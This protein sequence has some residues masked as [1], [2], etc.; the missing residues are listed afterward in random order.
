MTICKE[1]KFEWIYGVHPVLSFLR[2]QNQFI[3]HITFTKKFLNSEIV[4]Q[5]KN[6]GV[7]TKLVDE[8]FFRNFPVGHQSIACLCDV[9][10]A[11]TDLK[12]FVKHISETSTIVVL[13]SVTDPQN[14]GSC[15]RSALALGATT[16][17]I[18]K[19]QSASI[20]PVVHKISVGGASQLPIFRVVNISQTLELLK[21]H[22]F[23]IYGTCERATKSLHEIRIPRRNVIVF[24][25]EGNG[26]R[27]L[28][29]KKVDV[30]YKIDTNK[31]F[32]SLNVATA[33][34]LSLYQ[35]SVCRNN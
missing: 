19:H 13:D 11:R 8:A 15:I 22:H 28:T 9:D 34:A 30:L 21:K 7:E 14:F 2:H 27:Q 5:A 33:C 31:L 16:L 24:G 4:Q 20:S 12:E 3:Q 35:I 10:V 18:P 29:R 32:P 17:V 25:S 6:R 26:L 23:W 1:N